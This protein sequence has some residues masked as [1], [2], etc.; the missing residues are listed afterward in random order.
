MS[1]RCAK[2]KIRQDQIFGVGDVQ[3]VLIRVQF[4]TS[5]ILVTKCWR[6]VL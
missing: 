3:I 2:L 4:G 1:F 6:E 5:S